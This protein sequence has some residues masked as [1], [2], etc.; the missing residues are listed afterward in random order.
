L[1]DHVTLSNSDLHHRNK[2]H[3]KIYSNRNQ[4]NSNNISQC[5]C[6]SKYFKSNKCSISKNKQL[7]SKKFLFISNFRLVV[8]REYFTQNREKRQKDFLQCT[9]QYY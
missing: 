1:Q 8:H 2:F 5:Y 9:L 7:H 4:L 6:F 3:F